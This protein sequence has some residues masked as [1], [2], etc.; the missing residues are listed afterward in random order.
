MIT[1]SVITEIIKKNKPPALRVRT[2]LLTCIQYLAVL[3]STP[4]YLAASAKELN[5]LSTNPFSS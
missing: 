4:K 1:H 3:G 5:D 2:D